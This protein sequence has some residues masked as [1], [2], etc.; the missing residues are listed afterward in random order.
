MCHTCDRN[1]EEGLLLLR[2]ERRDTPNKTV[3]ATPLSRS[4]ESHAMSRDARER[5]SAAGKAPHGPFMEFKI[6]SR[7]RQS[8]LEAAVAAHHAEG[9]EAL[10]GITI[11]SSGPNRET[12]YSRVLVRRASAR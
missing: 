10:G 12:E 2:V 1:V 3:E 7:P 6:L 4:L 5:T 9:W 8:E 11:S